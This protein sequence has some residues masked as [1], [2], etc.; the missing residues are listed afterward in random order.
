[1]RY[2]Q[3]QGLGINNG[4]LRGAFT[5]YDGLAQ[6]PLNYLGEC[7]GDLRAGADLARP[8]SLLVPFRSDNE[9]EILSWLDGHESF[10][11]DP[12]LRAEGPTPIAESLRLAR[13][14]FDEALADDA[15]L[16]CRKNYVIV[17]TD[18]DESCVPPA[19][20]VLGTLLDRTVALRQMDVAPDVGPP[21]RKDVKVFF[22][23]FA[24]TPRIVA[25]LNALAQAGGTAVNARGEVDLFNGQAYSA[26]DSAGLR[27]AFSRILAEAIPSEDCNGLDDDC[28]DRVDEGTLNACGQCGAARGT[29]AAPAGRCPPRP[30]TSSTTTVTAPSTRPSSTRAAGAQPFDPMSATAWTTTATASWT[31]RPARQM[32]S[33]AAAAR[34]EASASRASRP[35]W[36]VSSSA[37]P[38]LAPRS[39]SA[40]APTTTVT[41]P[42]TR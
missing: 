29:P 42:P 16:R 18:G 30:V 28:D 8:F 20:D 14:Y 32:P 21:V 31:T 39:R 25:Q 24:V 9:R 2:P 3:R 19:N 5:A 38:R 41:A 13:A 37:A 40:T 15:G 27:R 6:R 12:E 22:V 11:V 17:L 26:N 1:M 33:N 34:T 4:A 23:G 35:A 10:P 36:G 7:S